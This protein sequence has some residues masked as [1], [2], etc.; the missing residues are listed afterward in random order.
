MT[1][2]KYLE[3]VNGERHLKDFLQTEAV[4]GGIL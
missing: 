2:S 4:D 1:K 3:N